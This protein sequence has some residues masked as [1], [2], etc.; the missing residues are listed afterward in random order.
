MDFSSLADLIE[1]D[2][3]NAR[4]GIGATDDEIEAARIKLDAPLTHGYA[5]FLKR[6]GWLELGGDEIFGL[7]SDVPSH[8]DVVANTLSERTEMQPNIPS[9]LIPILND[10][11]GNHYCIDASAI[12]SAAPQIVFWDH[13]LGTDQIGEPVS[14]T[15]EIW[16]AELFAGLHVDR[17]L[18]LQKGLTSKL[19][20]SFPANTTSDVLYL[21]TLPR[22][23]C[24]TLDDEVWGF[25][26]HG[27][28]VRFIELCRLEIIDMDTQI[29][30]PD[31]FSAGRFG[32]YLQSLGILE[33][34]ANSTVV[35]ELLQHTVGT[36][37]EII[38]ID[39]KSMYRA[40]SPS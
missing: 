34:V 31:L 28:G 2:S 24:I 40:I 23:A 13:E 7:G 26:K 6:F 18:R 16:L 20:D 14:A 33:G 37:L 36:R 17:F 19:F 5:S 27:L 32:H 4:Y 35:T 12:G 11:F 8:L 38:S 30:Q 9:E 1:A 3:L 25:A 21:S 29:F 39:D 22:S 10:G 15:F